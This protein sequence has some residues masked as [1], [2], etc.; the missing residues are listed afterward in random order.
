LPPPD[1]AEPNRVFFFGEASLAH[2]TACTLRDL[3]NLSGAVREFQHSVRTRRAET[4]TRTHAVTLGYLGAVLAR[5]GNLDEACA[6]WSVSLDA[7][8]GIRSGRTR[9]VATDIRATLA[10]LRRRGLRSAADVEARAGV[11]L[12]TIH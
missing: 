11:Y 1:D 9:Q 6:T 8:E 12:S 3:G 7:M 10:P 2:E 4:F 5:Q